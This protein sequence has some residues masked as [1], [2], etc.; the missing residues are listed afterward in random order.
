M[1]RHG[2]AGDALLDT[3]TAERRPLAVAMVEHSTKTGKLIDAYAEMAGGGPEPP[4]ELQR[5]AYGGDSRLPDLSHGLLVPGGG[6]WVGRHVPLAPVPTPDGERPLDD[7]V[8]PR[9]AVVARDDPR[10][11]LGAATR[12][13]LHD[14]GAV[15][16]AIPDP[17]GA[18]DALLAAHEVVVV[19]PDRIVYGVASVADF[20]ALAAR[21][22]HHLGAPP[23]P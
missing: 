8:G 5:Y 9:W 12:R 15:V 13:L 19:R 22:R 17:E 1:V 11:R 23:A 16:V 7:V 4:P 14:L 18:M 6:D 3:Y 10:P 20:D 2:R 21:L